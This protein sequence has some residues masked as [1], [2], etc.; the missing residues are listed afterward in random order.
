MPLTDADY[1]ALAGFRRGLREF[2]AFSQAQARAVGISPQQHQAML[3]IRG[4]PNQQLTVGELAAEVLIKPH[5]ALAL[6]DR[7]IVAGLVKRTGDEVDRRRVILML[8]PKAKGLLARLSQAHLAE[9]SHQRGF[10]RDLL[11]HLTSPHDSDAVTNSV[12]P[13][14]RRSR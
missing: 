4:R 9:L 3:A 10:L 11:S 14:P 5:S 7:L 1:S 12:G 2:I 13:R 8:T 6:A